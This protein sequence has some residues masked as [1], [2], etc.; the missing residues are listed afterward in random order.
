MR[1]V[2]ACFGVALAVAAL[3]AQAPQ[4]PTFRSTTSLVLVDVSVLDQDG[5]PVSG[6]GAD[7]FEVKLNGQVRPVKTV[8][9][10]EAAAKAAPPVAAP[11][12]VAAPVASNATAAGDPRVFIVMADDLS[13][14][15]AR[16]KSLFFAAARF[17]AGLPASDAVGFTTSSR[18]AMLNP[19][20]DA[21]RG[22]H[23]A[24][25]ANRTPR[26]NRLGRPLDQRSAATTP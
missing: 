15:P 25:H 6:L 18:T 5:R 3:S 7:D 4:T 20:F 26:P 16:G 9:Y 17:V 8:I 14:T 2:C 19:T 12:D 24:A 13:I 11:T 23:L 10:E 21:P 1:H 22:L